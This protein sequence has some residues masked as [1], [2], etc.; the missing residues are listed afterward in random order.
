MYVLLYMYTFL[1]DFFHDF[2]G[3]YMIISAHSTFACTKFRF[4]YFA[5][6]HSENLCL[7][8]YVRIRYYIV[9]MY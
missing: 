8:K 6:Y 4:I 9:Y 3:K 7:A 2:E 1:H 5:N